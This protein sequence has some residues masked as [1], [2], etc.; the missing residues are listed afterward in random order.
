VVPSLLLRGSWC[1][2]GYMT[3]ETTHLILVY[4]VMPTAQ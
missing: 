3:Q 1:K 2:Y 4:R